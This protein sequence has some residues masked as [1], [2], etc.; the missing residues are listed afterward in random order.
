MRNLLTEKPIEIAAA[1]VALCALFLSLFQARESVYQS[2]LSVVPIIQIVTSVNTDTEVSIGVMNSGMGPAVVTGVELGGNRVS[3]FDFVIQE[4]NERL[5]DTPLMLKVEATE[6]AR[7]VIIEPGKSLDF[8]NVDLLNSDPKQLIVFS[9][10]LESY[11]IQICYRSVYGD[12]FHSSSIGSIPKDSS[13]IYEGTVG[14]FG[15]RYRLHWPW[16]VRLNQNDLL[17]PGL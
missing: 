9:E 5:G 7:T 14:I 4:F 15:D 16:Q 8:L 6:L 17:G 12:V 13:C 11:S 1:V 2:R 10:H 3:S